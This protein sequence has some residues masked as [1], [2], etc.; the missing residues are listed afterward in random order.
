MAARDLAALAWRRRLRI[1]AGLPMDNWRILAFAVVTILLLPRRMRTIAGI[2]AAFFLLRDK[3]LDPLDPAVIPEISIDMNK[4][5]FRQLAEAFEQASATQ[6]LG[7]VRLEKPT[8]GYLRAV[9]TDA[10]GVPFTETQL[11]PVA[12]DPGGSRLP[13]KANPP[14]GLGGTLEGA[15][16][17][18][19]LRGRRISERR[20]S[21]PTL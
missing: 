12:P 1:D 7:G 21:R 11:W 4:S 14:G 2:I 5:Q 15:R 18:H 8:D 20:H 6:R 3:P 19:H 13:E 10:D 17:G 9:F 16:R